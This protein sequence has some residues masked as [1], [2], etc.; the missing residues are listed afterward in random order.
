MKQKQYKKTVPGLRL[1]LEPSL[2]NSVKIT[3]SSDL[4][5]FIR[6]Y[7]SDDIDIYESFWLVLLNRANITK[8]I[9]KISQGGTIGTVIDVK[10]IA[11]YAIEG[12]AE[13]CVLVHNHPS[14]N[15]YPSEPDKNITDRIK[16]ALS[17]FDIKV[18][19]H[20]ILAGDNYFSF[21]DE[22]LL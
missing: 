17:L 7:Y 2:I 10:L 13:S 4:N 12:L 20:I 21:A 22:C 14:G 5:D 9:V 16:T 18:I 11:K 19:D 1:V 6:Q 15:K 3:R 8:S